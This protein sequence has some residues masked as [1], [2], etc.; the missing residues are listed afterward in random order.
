MN[1]QNRIQHDI[2][3][4]L[5]RSLVEAGCAS[6]EQKTEYYKTLWSVIAKQLAQ[7]TKTV[8]Q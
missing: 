7:Q 2:R 1:T 6:A 3:F 8:V 5:L 4:E